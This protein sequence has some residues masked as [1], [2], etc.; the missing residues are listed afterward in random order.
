MAGDVDLIEPRPKE[1]SICGDNERYFP[2]IVQFKDF[3]GENKAQKVHVAHL[4]FR[5]DET[6][7]RSQFLAHF[8]FTPRLG[9]GPDGTDYQ[10][11]GVKVNPVA[12]NGSKFSPGL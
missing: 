8:S 7:S 3:Q 6:T 4:V 1:L 9:N 10:M 5:V 11:V 2:P 12:G